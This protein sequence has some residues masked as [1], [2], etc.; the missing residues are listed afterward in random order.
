LYFF[1]QDEIHLL[2]AESKKE[3]D[4]WF[5]ALKR[6]AYSRIGGGELQ[7]L[8]NMDSLSCSMRLFRINRNIKIATI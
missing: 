3:Y 5:L 4:C 7:I 8:E 2:Q 1:F 6:T